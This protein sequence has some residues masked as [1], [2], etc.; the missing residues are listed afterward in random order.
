MIPQSLSSLNQ[1][2]LDSAGRVST[3][4]LCTCIIPKERAIIS[5]AAITHVCSANFLPNLILIYCK[6]NMHWSFWDLVSPLKYFT[7]LTRSSRVASSSHTNTVCGCCWNADTVHIWF[8]PSSIALYKANAL[9]APVM[10]IMTWEETE[11]V[12]CG[13]DD[14]V[15]AIW[16][17]WLF[18]WQHDDQWTAVQLKLKLWCKM[19]NQNIEYTWYF[20]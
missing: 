13:P 6:W 17:W 3:S 4:L 20:A 5:T 14:R 10:R 12:I 2:F 9:C 15:T 7:V 8:T 19:I 11:N 1:I 18:V 16:N